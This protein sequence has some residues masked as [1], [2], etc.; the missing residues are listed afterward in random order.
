MRGGSTAPNYDPE[1]VSIAE[2]VLRQAKL[3]T[4]VMVDCSH[5]NCQKDFRKQP[6]ALSSV[7]SQIRSGNSSLVGVMIESNLVAGKQSF[8]IPR[9]QLVYGQSITDPCVDFPTT[10][11]MLRELAES[12]K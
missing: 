10:V 4:R 9:R 5:G 2:T 1:S 3:C 6:Q 12:A 11:T 7:A 8:P